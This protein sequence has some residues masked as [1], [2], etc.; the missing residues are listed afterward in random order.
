VK[1]Y[2]AAAAVEALRVVEATGYYQMLLL[3]GDLISCSTSILYCK[4][5]VDLRWCLYLLK[6]TNSMSVSNEFFEGFVWMS[7]F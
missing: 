7:M 5:S 6:E 4:S 1:I 3:V 2:V